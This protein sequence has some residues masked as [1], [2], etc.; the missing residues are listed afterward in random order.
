MEE[1]AVCRPSVIHKKHQKH[2]QDE[3]HEDREAY[4]RDQAAAA[5]KFYVPPLG[6][7]SDNQQNGQ[8]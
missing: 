7:K 2:D 4:Q 5:Q 6:C 1:P 8:Q 3:N